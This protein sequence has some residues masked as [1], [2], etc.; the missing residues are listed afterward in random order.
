M[1]NENIFFIIEGS[2]LKFT[3]VE[4]QIATYFLDEKQPVKQSV[5]AKKINVSTSSITRFC[6]KIGFDNYKEFIFCY[7]RSLIE[8]ASD[9]NEVTS[10]LQLRYKELIDAI[11]KSM[12]KEK[13]KKACEY[14]YNHKIIH[15]YGLGLSAISGEDFKFRF[16]R[17]G[18]YVEV[19]HDY[20]SIEM[21]SSLLNH[22]NLVIYFSLRG[23]NEHVIQSLKEL[24]EK[25]S[26]LIIITSNQSEKIR[27]LADVTLLTSNIKNK[28]ELGQISAQI[29]LLIII[30]MIYSQYINMYR[31]N[32]SKWLGTEYAYLYGNKAEKKKHK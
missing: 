29:P 27:N 28:N 18:K 14:I 21:I 12:D 9:R 5:L 32:I 30:D 22:E 20:D 13:V 8:Y 25:K 17:I 19:V 23:E 15:V 11:D 7:R 3:A 4:E 1:S 16:T 31:E 24:K 2:K 26:H 10:N 6:K